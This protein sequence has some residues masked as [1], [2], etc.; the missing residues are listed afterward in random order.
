MSKMTEYL[1]AAMGYD[2]SGLPAAT[3][4]FTFGLSPFSIAETERVEDVT[5]IKAICQSDAIVD[6]RI[7]D[8]CLKVSFDFSMETNI[9]AEFAEELEIYEQ[10]KTHVTESLNDLMAQRAV[11]QKNEDEAELESVEL[12]I[13]AM[14]VP[15]LIPTILPVSHGGS[16]HISFTDDPKFVFFVSDHLNQAPSKVVMIF[17]VKALFCQDEV[18]IYTEDTEEEIRAQQEELWYM[19][20]AKKAEEE[21]YQA[22]FGASADYY[23]Q[24]DDYQDD[25]R[26]RG[27]RIK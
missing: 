2:A 3:T 4:Q 27:V 8:D 19:Q 7:I 24:E 12:Q 20:E 1:G 10:Q 17:D 22:Q 16:V 9:L 14:S 11:A 5:E 18:G 15:F 21:A 25:K 13:R 6:L 26:L 23:T